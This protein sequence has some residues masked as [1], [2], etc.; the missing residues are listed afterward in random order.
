VLRA[1]SHRLD[2]EICVNKS[3]TVR[4]EDAARRCTV[5]IG[6]GQSL[7][8]VGKDLVLEDPAD[9]LRPKPIRRAGG[10]PGSAASARAREA[11]LSLTLV[12]LALQ[13]RGFEAA[14]V[15][16]AV[17]VCPGARLEMRQCVVKSQVCPGSACC[18]APPTGPC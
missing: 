6:F 5:S 14:E 3:L 15:P 13:Q 17:E 8:T 1:A 7:F 18:R 16:I 12:G 2:G 4:A 10:R 9:H 11:P